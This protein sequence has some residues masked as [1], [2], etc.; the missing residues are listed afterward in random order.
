MGKH[1]K[2]VLFFCIFSYIIS[3]TIKEISITKE[4]T[5]VEEHGSGDFE[6]KFPQG[7]RPNYLHIK[8]E[9]EKNP[10]ILV[11]D[12]QCKNRKAV[13]LQA[14]NP[15]NLIVLKEEIQ[16]IVNKGQNLYV[17]VKCRY[18]EDCS[19][20]IKFKL[21]DICE[22]TLGEQI[23]FYS[24]S[25]NKMNF[26]FEDKE[27]DKEEET[28]LLKRNLFTIKN[29]A[30]IWVKGQN[31]KTVTL[32]K[33]DGYEN[34]N[35]NSFGFGYIFMLE[36]IDNATYQLEIEL[37]QEDYVTIGSLY[38]RNDNPELKDFY[39]SI[40]EL[41]FND[42]EMMGILNKEINNICFPIKK[43][44]TEEVQIAQVNGRIFTKKAKVYFS[45]NGE[46]LELE[47]INN[48]LIFEH[49]F[50]NNVDDTK[51]CV[52]Y[53]DSD[54]KQHVVIFAFQLTIGG[55]EKYSQFISPPQL[56]GVIY[57]H[58]L[59][60]GQIAVFRGM[61]PKKGAKE[62]N[63][64]MKTV[65]GFPDMLFDWTNDFPFSVYDNNKITTITNPHHA[66]RMSVYSIYLNNT[67]YKDFD[68]ISENQPL[69]IVQCV[70]GVDPEKQN[71]L[72]CEF[73]TS[74]FTDLDRINLIKDEAFSQYLLGGESDLY[75][76]NIENEDN[77]EK[78]YLDLIIFSGDVNVEIENSNGLEAH[79]YYLSN[80]IFYSIR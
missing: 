80:K 73:E 19:Y 59:L 61:K 41:Q 79:K 75:T 53:P 10:I 50:I 74:I 8:L 46:K 25:N 42:L 55:N 69:I 76:I 4:E 24:K 77:L 22:L 13:G 47:E 17:C 60:K 7:F 54:E 51:F 29:A 66:N 26:K 40:H 71:S 62:I 30:N 45:M 68:P 56:P 9:S 2:I 1:L 16:T 5:D 15:I 70:D 36:D 21:E 14:Y 11:G 38:I 64:N 32:K 35:N 31:I 18:E 78:V 20:T 44:I 52:A 72:F 33:N 39:D 48:G 34:I 43:C 63:F 65:K 57:S 37:E 58:F 49:L 3:I 67:D 28:S 23:S 12:E 6:L 27:E